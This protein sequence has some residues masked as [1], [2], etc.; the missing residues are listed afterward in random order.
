MSSNRIRIESVTPTIGAEVSGIDLRA[1]TVKNDE[2][3]SAGPKKA[4]PA[5]SRPTDLSDM[6][7]ELS[8]LVRQFQ[9]NC[10][11]LVHG[12]FSPKNILEEVQQ[13]L[14]LEG[15]AYSDNVEIGIMIEVPS[16]V[17]MAD[18]LA[19]EADFFSI[20]TNDLIQYSLAIDRESL[21]IETR[22]L[23]VTPA[24]LA[25]ASSD[26]LLMPVSS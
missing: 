6:E 3:A 14:E 1:D 9:D 18:I 24:C 23:A 11:W 12:D 26:T 16:A 7:A 10:H 25:S 21:T 4:A 5:G 20:G 15:A 2:Q 17:M 19:E 8:G 22:S 13:E